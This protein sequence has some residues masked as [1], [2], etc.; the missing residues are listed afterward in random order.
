MENGA[1][2]PGATLVAEPC[3]HC[4]TP[5][6]TALI[7]DAISRWAGQEPAGPGRAGPP[8]WR[9]AGPARPAAAPSLN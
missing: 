6:V 1:L 9:N 3:I 7:N 8:E 2:R 4:V 5:K